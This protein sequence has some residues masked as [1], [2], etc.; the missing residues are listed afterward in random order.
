M[1]RRSYRLLWLVP[2]L[3][4]AGC[5]AVEAT[6]Q[7]KDTKAKTAEAPAAPAAKGATCKVEKADFKIEIPLKGV[8]EAE[9]TSEISLKPKA[10][11]PMVMPSSLIVQKAVE[12]G[13]AVKK[14]EVLVEFDLEK[15]DRALKDLREERKHTE[16]AIKQ[17]QEDLAMTEKST[18][19][20]LAAA[21]RAKK[22]ADEDLAKFLKVDRPL[23]EESAKHALENAEFAL[24]STQEELKQLQKMYR[25]KD[26]TE[27]TE[28]FIL[29]RQKHMVRFMEFQ[30]K[31]ARIHTD[32]TLRLDLPRRE[33][34][35]HETATKSELAWEKARDGLPLSLRQ[36]RLALEKLKYDAGK[37]RQKLDN[38]EEDRKLLT[39][40]SPADGI[41]YYGKATQGQWSTSSAAT[42]LQHGGSV[43]P[44]EVF[45]TVVQTRPL[46]VRA[47]VEEKDLHLLQPGLKGKVVVAGY[48]D[49]KLSGQVAQVSSIPQTPGNFEARVNVEPGDD[50]KAI[51][52]GM[53][54]SVKVLAY[55]KKNVLVVPDSA[56]LS[57]DDDGHYVL[58]PV[59]GGKPE[60]RTVKIG[61]RWGGKTEILEGLNEGDEISCTKP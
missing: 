55:Q 34:N 49:V 61:K 12:Q 56:V 20:D 21:E 22:I 38:L 51:M 52:P 43:S 59:K 13:T 25:D 28:E 10:W 57:D 4:L 35:M 46:S 14:G 7:E 15:I 58:L 47:V 2:A 53:A 26:L 45:M 50:A 19:I 23:A 17:A 36:K 60:H 27:E 48:P 40:H 1:V 5:E 54:C 44:E 31:S 6:E 42:K 9:H 3:L 37:A 11:T 32:D 8:L 29:R 39:V 18:P 33:V 41:V 24:Q 30:L 16:I